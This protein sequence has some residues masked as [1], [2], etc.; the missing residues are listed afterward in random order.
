M[1][2]A[3]QMAQNK[4][5]CPILALLTEQMGKH[6]YKQCPLFDPMFYRAW[7]FE[8]TLAFAKCNCSDYLL[9]SDKDDYFTLNSRIALKA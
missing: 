2:D 4:T 7:A 6:A 1:S 5:A 3:T 8:V 9:T